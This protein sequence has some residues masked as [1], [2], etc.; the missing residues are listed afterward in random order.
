[1]YW[2]HSS[3]AIKSRQ[4]DLL[5]LETVKTIST[6]R[7]INATLL[8]IKTNRTKLVSMCGYKLATNWQKFTEIHLAEVKILQ[9]VF[10]FFWVGGGYFF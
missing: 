3:L 10:S 6:P 1:M 4:S 8:N 2:G 9:K 7:K 5:K